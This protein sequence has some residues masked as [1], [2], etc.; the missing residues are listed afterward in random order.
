VHSLPPNID[1]LS[2]AFPTPTARQLFHHYCNS[3]SRI[4]ITMGNIGPNPLLSLCTPVK[5]LDTFSAAS[6]ALRMALLSASVTHFLWVAEAA[7]DH[8]DEHWERQKASMKA[9]SY[10][11]KQDALTYIM[12]AT[13]DE[14]ALR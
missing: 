12:L 4:L 7:L 2:N 11:F 10:K 5:L 3:T 9:L 13:G 8:P 14:D 6:A 1:V